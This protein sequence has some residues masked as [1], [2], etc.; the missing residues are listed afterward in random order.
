[1]REHFLN[2]DF[3]LSLTGAPSLLASSDPTYLHEM[4]WHFLFAADPEDS[5]VVHAPLPAGFRTYLASK[6]LPAPRTVLH[7][8]YTRGADF[9]PF[10]WNAQAEA[11]A[12]RYDRP[13]SAPDSGVVK[14]VNARSFA[15]VLEREWYPGQTEGR[16]YADAAA[17]GAFLA[18]R[19][20]GESWVAKGEHGF[21]GTANRRVSGG[22]PDADSAALLEPLFAGHGRVLLEPWHERLADMAVLFTV[23][24]GGKV[25]EFRGH[26]LLNSRDGAF[27]GAE[28]SP[29]GHPPEPWREA[30]RDNAARLARALSERGSFQHIGILSLEFHVDKLSRPLL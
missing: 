11:L 17:L 25:L 12:A 3:D 21:A 2:A 1:M 26:S 6:G 24:A 29:E 16:V 8:D 15:L 7:P 5:I 22:P 13:P 28:L 14:A 20:V 10:G 27:L 30:L 19:P 23:G 18:G 4:A 9:I